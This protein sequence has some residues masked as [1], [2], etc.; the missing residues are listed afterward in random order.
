[1]YS[2]LEA[3]E[4]GIVAV[5]TGFETESNAKVFLDLYCE[6]NEIS[7]DRFILGTF[8]VPYVSEKNLIQLKR[9]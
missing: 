9:N 8:S 6:E 5:K 3:K 1:M 2:I 4:N 7:P